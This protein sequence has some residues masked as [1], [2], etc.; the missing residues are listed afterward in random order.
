MGSV[1]QVQALL[2]WEYKAYGLL[3][4]EMLVFCNVLGSFLDIIGNQPH[5]AEGRESQKE[6]DR[7]LQIGR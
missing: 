2:F 4:F 5:L 1:I 6:T 3:A 7:S